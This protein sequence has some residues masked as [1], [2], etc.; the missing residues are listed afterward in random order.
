MASGIFVTGTG[1]GVGKTFVSRAITAAMRARAERVVALKPIE[2]GW[3]ASNADAVVL[4]TACGKSQLAHAAGLYRADE[5]L[6]PYA[7]QLLGSRPPLDTKALTLVVQKLSADSEFVVIEGAG[8]FHVPLNPKDTIADFA[9]QLALPILLVSQNALGVLSDVLSTVEG[10][11][12]RSLRLAAVVL[13]PAPAQDQSVMHNQQI[14]AERLDVPVICFPQCAADD[15]EL[16]A[17]A[18][19]CG[20]ME[21]WPISGNTL[22]LQPNPSRV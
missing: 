8:G 21:M 1:T 13:T 20:L 18:A 7:I 2:T 15:A 3:D 17:A 12:Q 22:R 6:A 5:P 19:R 14:L 11:Q 4:A 9:E 16:A 10:I